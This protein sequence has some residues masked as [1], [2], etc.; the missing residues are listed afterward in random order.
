MQRVQAQAPEETKSLK[1]HVKKKDALRDSGLD[2]SRSSS[3]TPSLL[4]ETNRLQR[5]NGGRLN[6]NAHDSVASTASINSIS[7]RSARR[8]V[9]KAGGIPVIVVPSRLSS[10][11]STS[12]EPSLRSTSSRRSRRS[13]SLHSAPPTQVSK[14]REISPY[15]GGPPSRRSRAYSESEGST[16][17]SSAMDGSAPGDQRTIDFPPTI[18]QRSSSL[19]APTSRN[20]SRSGSLT[21]ESIHAHSAILR[22]CLKDQATSQPD[23]QT[24]LPRPGNLAS[25][26]E[27]VPQN[28]RDNVHGDNGNNNDDDGQ[29]NHLDPS[30]YPHQNTSVLVVDHSTRPSDSSD[31]SPPDRLTDPTGISTPKEGSSP[32][33]VFTAALAPSSVSAP[34]PEQPT[35]TTTLP[36]AKE[37]TP[38]TPT[39]QQLFSL[40]DV[41]SPLRN[42][43]SP[44]EPPAINLIP[45]TPSGL[46]PS[47]E[48]DKQRGN[49]FE[50]TRD[51]RPRRG[52]SVS[53]VLRRALS[54][55]H[56]TTAEYGPSA[57]RSG[58]LLTR[59]LSLTRDV[60]R[61]AFPLRRSD[62]VD[63]GQRASFDMDPPE[64]DKLHPF[65]RPASFHQTTDDDDYD[66]E[67]DEEE[68][69]RYPPIDNRPRGPRRSL[70]MRMKRTF[71][72]LPTERQD[73]FYPAT[74]NDGPERRTVRRTP[75]GNLRVVK[76][77]G[78][79]ESLGEYTTP[80]NLR[81][82]TA[83]E[84]HG[85]RKFWFWRSPSLSRVKADQMRSH[86][87][88]NPDVDA[89]HQYD[90]TTAATDGEKKALKILPNLGLGDKIGE[91]GPHTIP[92]RF[93]ERRREKRSNELRQMIS[94]PQ[95]VRDG[96]GEV[97]RRTNYRDAFTQAQV[98]G[99]HSF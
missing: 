85:S 17:N 84:R 10:V 42:P 50:E 25:K 43:R 44:P 92:R 31:D 59:T 90:A 4:E 32:A 66:H 45:A 75:S 40:D 53:A 1:T 16:R 51:G 6:G 60:Q 47:T 87:Y 46:T 28:D 30:I 35:I 71:A 82:Y 58:G 9:W 83:P 74:S 70:S 57:S 88:A 64:E 13:Q 14:S 21:A 79:T 89:M 62:S 38:V 55:G 99:D 12:R 8:E 41:D 24:M 15:V 73:D 48:R 11:R 63:R 7:S 29:R 95:E 26:S 80:V 96:V 97:I 3:A 52:S 33:S 19:S 36:D 91:Y 23:S 18:P 22:A 94:G 2:L 5:P 61:R 27:D 93:S 72:I 67:Y 65:W 69:Y 98:S 39:Y 86:E 20:V 68:T 34:P 77:H 81:P 56:S 78:S 37:D 49:Y 54:R 76:H